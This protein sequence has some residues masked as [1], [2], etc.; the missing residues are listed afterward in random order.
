MTRVFEN[1]V[2]RM[3]KEG[4]KTAGGWLQICSPLA[5]EV[6]AQAGFD[7]LLIDM[8]HGPGDVLTL[9]GQIQALQGYGVI[10]LVRAP[11]NDFVVIKRILDAG[12]YG[13]MVPYVN[14]RADAEAAVRA[15]RYPPQGIRGVARS[16]R[17]QGFGQNAQQYLARANEEI[18]TIVQI[19]TA[20]GISNLG[21]ILEVPGVD[22]IFIGPVDLASSLGHLGDPNH[23]EVRSAIATIEA[24]TLLAKKALGTVSPS[25]EKARELYERGYQ[26]VTLMSDGTSLA[27]LAAEIM[28]NFRKAFP[29][30]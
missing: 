17:A 11:W 10:P 3:L 1:R 16:P 18:L 12:A 15:C 28:A 25:W 19:E 23:T 5:A 4:K 27:G 14:T 13:V 7:W 21:S 6:M 8:E 22:V 29:G 30:G 2:K 24:Q 26:M 20:E 9:I